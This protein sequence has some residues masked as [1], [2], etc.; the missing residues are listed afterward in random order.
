MKTLT[1]NVA[2]LKILG[3]MTLE[4]THPLWHIHLLYRL[5][6]YSLLTLTAFDLLNIYKSSISLLNFVD[7]FP[8]THISVTAWLKASAFVFVNSEVKKLVPMTDGFK[9]HEKTEIFVRKIVIA[10]TVISTIPV[11]IALLQPR[12]NFNGKWLPFH[13]SIPF[14]YRDDI[15]Y[16]MVIH[17]NRLEDIILTS[18]TLKSLFFI[19]L[20]IHCANQLR[21]IQENFLYT[22]NQIS[23][24]RVE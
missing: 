13:S 1:I 22:I 9:K 11:T 8:A 3:L 24:M 6:T 20:F 14:D 23:L 17:I 12:V 21:V 5:I 18:S 7:I 10:A 19:S 15:Q 2:I 4:K 16:I